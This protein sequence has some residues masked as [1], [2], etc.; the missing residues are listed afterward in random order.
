[1][2]RRNS[3]DFFLDDSRGEEDW[4]VAGFYVENEDTIYGGRELY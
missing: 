2:E 1:M 4:T 3:M